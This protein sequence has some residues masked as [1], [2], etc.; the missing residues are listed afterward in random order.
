[1]PTRYFRAENA[2][3]RRIGGAEFEKVDVV[4]GTVIGVLAAEGALADTLASLS[5]NPGNALEE[6]TEEQ[7]A[8]AVQKKMPS[9]ASLPFSTP[10]SPTA[11]PIKPLA[12]PAVVQDGSPAPAAEKVLEKAE[13]AIALG[14]VKT[15]TPPPDPPKKSRK[16][17]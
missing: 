11:A 3:N 16:D 1:M 13:D 6:I 14:E 12:K 7:Y 5:K 2:A 17:K 9:L 10:S 15:E 8:Q 4:C